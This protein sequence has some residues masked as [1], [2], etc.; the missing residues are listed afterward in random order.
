MTKRKHGDDSPR[1]DGSYARCKQCKEFIP[2][3]NRSWVCPHCGAETRCK[4]AKVPGYHY[5]RNHGGPNP[6][7]NYYGH[8]RSMVTGEG[9]QFPITRLAARYNE[10]KKNGRLL[11]TRESI[12]IVRKRV[13]EL[14]SRIEQSQD[15]DRVGK[16]Q[17]LWNKY[18]LADQLDKLKLQLEIDDELEKAF[19]DYASWNQVFL[20]LD[21]DRKLV[22]SEVKVAKDMHAILTAEDA[23]ELVAKLLASIIDAVRQQKDVEDVSKAHILKRV[24]YEFTKIIGEGRDRTARESDADVIDADVPDFESGSGETFDPGAGGVD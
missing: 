5:C 13:V 20:A 4:D 11:S 2:R 12:D 19:H 17:K 8:G 7:N 3:E 24:E 21:L 16:I 14:L 22:E 18:K 15:P 1:C 9:S 23:Y 6:R 10:M